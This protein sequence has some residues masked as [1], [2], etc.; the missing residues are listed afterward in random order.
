MGGHSRADQ[1]S[2]DQIRREIF[3]DGLKGE[4][5]GISPLAWN[6][7]TQA[8]GEQNSAPVFHPYV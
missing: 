8:E 3:E 6:C 4:I 7:V 5:T 2:G 1:G